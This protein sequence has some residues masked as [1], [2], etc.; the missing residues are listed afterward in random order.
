MT[1]SP[2]TEPVFGPTNP[3]P[4]TSP[5]RRFGAVIELNPAME[6]EYRRLHAAVWPDVLDRLHRSGVRNY[7]IFI[8][9]LSG[10]RYLFSYYDYVGDDFEADLAAVAKDPATQEWWT[11]TDPC[12]RRLSG[13][14]DGKQWMPLESVFFA[15]LQNGRSVL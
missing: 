14:S 15:D 4:G 12:Q 9:E 2:S 3:A 7:N 11:L 6:H 8:A 13:T 1:V 5:T 10:Q